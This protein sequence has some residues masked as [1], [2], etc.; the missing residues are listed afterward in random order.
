MNGY[1]ALTVALVLSTAAWA[2]DDFEKEPISYSKGKPDNA[3]SR[4]QAR[5]AAGKA[6][7]SF[8]RDKGYLKSLLRELNVPVSSQALVF[9]KT[10][11]QRRRIA[12]KTPRA[13]Y[14]SDDVY[15]GYCQDG[16]VLEVSAVDTKL[17]TVFYTLQ[18]EEAKM[19]TFKR[20][21]DSCLLCHGSTQT[22]RV[23]GHLVRSVF[24]DYQGLPLLS[25]GSVRVDQTTPIDKRWGGWYVTG[26]HGKQTHVGNLIVRTRSV[27][28]PVENPDG[29]NVTKLA[30][31][32]DTSA[33]LSPHSD[34]VA[35]MVLEHQT[36]AH[37]YLTKANFTA[38]DAL[39]YE[40]TLNK[41][42]KLPASHRWDSAVSRIRG[43][44]EELLR[45]LLF[46]EEAPLS[47][48]IKGTS[49][50]AEEFAKRGPRDAK[51]R[52]LRD[53]DLKKRLFKYPLSY[54]IYS[55]AFDAL[56]S[57]MREYVLKRLWEVL[58][59]KDTHKDFTHLSAADRKAIREILVATKPN[60]PA[61]WRGKAK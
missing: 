19:P 50:F 34:I 49:G 10:S 39:H 25:A 40:Q 57:E 35:L 4:L 44:G 13:I 42:M 46:S 31:R 29:L 1:R 28:F 8:G 5:L 11:L 22:Q 60:L 6:K 23:P 43:A 7:L 30:G 37:N 27:S 41:E 45:Y 15:V 36:T 12:P 58:T 18:Q 59:G 54:L 53:F 61:Y 14:F 51:G 20:R 56:P 24:P 38:R 55:E 16:E 3:V 26:T 52:S 48:Q 47:G 33:Y 21:G 9:S 2:A 32:F 17:G